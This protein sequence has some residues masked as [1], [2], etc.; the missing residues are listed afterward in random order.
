MEKDFF[1]L[2]AELEL[3]IQNIYSGNNTDNDNEKDAE[4]SI[5]DLST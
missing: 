1:E 5:P 3:S 4:D 2:T